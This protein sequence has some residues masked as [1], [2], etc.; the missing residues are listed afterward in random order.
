MG[1]MS[2]MTIL[3][4]EGWHWRTGVIWDGWEADGLL[5]EFSRPA[6]VRVAQQCVHR[7]MFTMR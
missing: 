7:G 1:V 4:P 6:S 5:W 3:V 2:S